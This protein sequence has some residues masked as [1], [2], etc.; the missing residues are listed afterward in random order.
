MAWP[1]YRTIHLVCNWFVIHYIRGYDSIS[2]GEFVSEAW[3]R[4]Q[5]EFF[6]FVAGVVGP[7]GE[8]HRRF[9]A[10]PGL[11]P[12][13]RHVRHGHRGVGHPPS[14]RDALA[15]ALLA[16]AVRALIDTRLMW[17][18]ERAGPR[19]FG[20]GHAPAGSGPCRNHR[21]QQARGAIPRLPG[22]RRAAEHGFRRVRARLRDLAWKLSGLTDP[23]ANA[24]AGG[25]KGIGTIPPRS[26]VALAKAA[27]ALLLVLWAASCQT[28]GLPFHPFDLLGVPVDPGPG[29]GPDGDPCP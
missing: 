4:F 6:P 16:K 14:D 11:A 10:V 29:C 19:R 9:V 25:M 22:D 8:R 15:R 21:P 18:A 17:R 27:T 2:V 23:A 3:Y 1:G 13:E 7:L 20:P 28:H 26:R 24:Y 12:V 5:G